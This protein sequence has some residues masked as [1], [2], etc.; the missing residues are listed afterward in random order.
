MGSVG[1]SRLLF[2][3][4]I[5]VYC[6]FFPV[7][8]AARV[9]RETGFICNAGHIAATLEPGC[10][11]IHSVFFWEGGG[12]ENLLQYVDGVLLLPPAVL[13]DGDRERQMGWS[14]LFSVRQTYATE[15]GRQDFMQAQ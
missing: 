14:I 6:P 4:F 8:S 5:E 1:Y 12:W 11:K 2:L 10:I 15:L 9:H 13:T 3:Q 7:L